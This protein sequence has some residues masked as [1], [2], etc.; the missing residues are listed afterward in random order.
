MNLL[1]GWLFFYWICLTSH[2]PRPGPEPY[3]TTYS[4]DGGKAKET[5]NLMILNLIWSFSFSK[6]ISMY[7]RTKKNPKLCNRS[8]WQ[9]WCLQSLGHSLT[10]LNNDASKILTQQHVSAL[11]HEGKDE[12]SLMTVTIENGNELVTAGTR[13]LVRVTWWCKLWATGSQELPSYHCFSE[14]SCTSQSSLT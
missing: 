9:H 6:T 8:D 12:C 14:F 11:T 1:I 13:E 7:K 2:S 5:R 4:P 10:A 3:Y